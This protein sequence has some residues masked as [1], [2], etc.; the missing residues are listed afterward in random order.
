MK[1]QELIVLL[2][3]HKPDS[4]VVLAI[5]TAGGV[6]ISRNFAVCDEPDGTTEL[7]GISDK[8]RVRK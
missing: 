5:E 3:T 7:T 1:V 8:Y 2:L 6:V 4:K